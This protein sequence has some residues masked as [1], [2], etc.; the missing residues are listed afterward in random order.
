VPG[1][2]FVPDATDIAGLLDRR[3]GWL[4]GNPWLDRVPAA[5][6]G[7]PTLVDGRAWFVDR[8]GAALPIADDLDPWPLLA[9]TGGTRTTIFG[10]LEH[11]TLHPAT[12]TV[13]DRLVPL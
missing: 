10:E 13:D 3:A 12:V 7:V 2:A 8:A 6:V 9:L 5:L 1:E 11:G 4:A